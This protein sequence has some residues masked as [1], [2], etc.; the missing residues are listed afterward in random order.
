MNA[1]LLAVNGSLA[2]ASLVT[3]NTGGTLGGSGSVGGVSVLSGG[4]I[5]PGN[6]V[7]T[8]TVAGNLALAA[9]STTVIEVQG[10]VADRINVS[11]TANLGG[12]LRLAPLGGAYNFNTPYVIVQAGA[13]TG[14]FATVNTT[15]SFGVGV[16]VAVTTTATQVLLGLTPTL[17]LAAPTNALPGFRTFNLR[18]TAGALDAANRA[19]GN[20][21]PFFR[22][23]NQSAANITA[24]VNQ[25]SGEVA[26]AGPA[27]A[28]AA[29]DQFLSAMLD[30]L[31]YGRESMLG[32]RLRA[33]AP[34][35][36]SGLPYAVWGRA[37]GGFSRTGGD[38]ADGSAAR[39]TRVAG[40]V[41]GF[42]RQL[43]GQGVV[44]GA[45]AV[46]DGEA[47]LSQ[48]LG[49]ARGT[50]GQFGVHGATRLAGFTFSG[51]LAGT[52]LDLETRR[53][54]HF[55]GQDRQRGD[56]T[57]WTFSGR[58]E[59]RQD[60]QLLGGVRLQPY[61]ALQWHQLSADGYTERSG[62]TGTTLGQR[63]SGGS[64]GMVRMELGGQA[65]GAFRLGGREVRGFG[66]LAW[67]HYLVRDFTMGM[68]FAGLPNAG[69]TVRGARGDLNAALLAL[70]AETAIAPRVTLGMRLDSEL[71]GGVQQISGT[72]RLR[73]VF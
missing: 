33:G 66:R 15:G 13:V 46:G 65:D 47:T 25:L 61:A 58:V 37:Y 39:S 23:Y 11:G 62:L 5:A 50:Y 51:A 7:G 20:L 26:T 54:L 69:F 27:M 36:S 21:D 48:G 70:G 30:P 63:V 9:G 22:V 19:G 72:A 34:E 55:L 49:T 53:T 1:G 68:G 38:G 2:P 24:A 29:G 6:S 28:F 40:F 17:L 43:A 73:H 4:S 32:G 10:P 57:S 64:H 16:N 41:L 12:T 45:I 8:L 14:N 67:G 18:A 60:G 42:D 71:A 52:Y 59:A 31:G 35:G 3:V 44:G 56:G